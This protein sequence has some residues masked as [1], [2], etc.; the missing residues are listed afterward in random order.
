MGLHQDS[1]RILLVRKRPE[2]KHSA[3]PPCF[4][5]LQSVSTRA[6]PTGRDTVKAKA[7]EVGDRQQAST[8]MC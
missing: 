7:Y 1:A 4:G 3:K 8:L 5:H 6:Q 2:T